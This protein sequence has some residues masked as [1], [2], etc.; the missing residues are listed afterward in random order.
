MKQKAVIDLDNGYQVLVS[1]S[2]VVAGFI[3]GRGYVVTDHWYSVT[4][5]RHINEYIAGAPSETIGQE[6]LTALLP[7][8][9][10]RIG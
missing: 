1:Y 6:E 7:V 4:T 8:N 9:R 2:T 5:S 10:I 3:P